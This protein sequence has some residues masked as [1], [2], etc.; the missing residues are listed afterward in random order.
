LP[1]HLL[2]KVVDDFNS[3]L[4]TIHEFKNFPSDLTAKVNSFM[5]DHV[6][7]RHFSQIQEPV[8]VAEP[9]TE[10]LTLPGDPNI[11]FTSFADNPIRNFSM[12]V[13]VNCV[14]QPE[15]KKVAAEIIRSFS[16]TAFPLR[17]YQARLSLY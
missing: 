12:F 9:H 14:A 2:L 6:S 3:Y 17:T 7:Y 13:S 4:L 16:M 5:P 8:G 15:I 1:F 10:L 11:S